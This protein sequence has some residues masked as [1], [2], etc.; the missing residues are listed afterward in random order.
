MTGRVSFLHSV[1]GFGYLRADFTAGRYWFHAR[2]LVNVNFDSLTPGSRVSF[3]PAASNGPT[4]V[5]RNIEV[6][7]C[8]SQAG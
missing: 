2:D 8:Q 7:S 3:T 1:R 6:E 4:P 5:A